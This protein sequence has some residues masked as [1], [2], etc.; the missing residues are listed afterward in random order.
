VSQQQVQINELNRAVVHLESRVWGNLDLLHSDLDVLCAEHRALGECLVAT[1]MLRLTTIRARTELCWTFGLLR[2]VLSHSSLLR[3]VSQSADS[4]GSAI[5]CF[6]LAARTLQDVRKQVSHWRAHGEVEVS[7]SGSSTS[8]AVP[9][10][11]S[12][13]SGH[14]GVADTPPALSDKD[15]R[16]LSAG[17][18][19][20]DAELDKWA[21]S[22]AVKDILSSYV[23]EDVV[24]S[25]DTMRFSDVHHIFVDMGLCIAQFVRHFTSEA[26]PRH[27]C[28]SADIA[29]MANGILRRFVSNPEDGEA[30]VIRHRDLFRLLEATGYSLSRFCA[31]FTNRNPEAPFVPGR[32]P[33]FGN[34]LICR[35]IGAG[36]HG[37][38]CYL[39]QHVHSAAQVAIK[40]PVDLQEL[41]TIRDIQRHWGGACLG[42]ARLID[43]GKYDGHLYMVTELL[44][45]TF[46]K[47]FSR[48][49]QALPLEQRWDALSIIGR[50]LVR[51]L[52]ALH[53]A[54]HVHCDISPENILLGHVHC[55]GEATPFCAPFFI[56][57]GLARKYPDGGVLDGQ[58]G[59]AEWNSISSADDIERR[60]EDDLEAL[61]WVMLTGLFGALPWMDWLTK[62]Y[63]DWKTPSTRNGVLRRV[64]RAKIQLLEAG[65]DSL[66]GWASFAQ[67]PRQLDS[68]LRECRSSEAPPGQPDYSYLLALLGCN[69][70]L[71]T[72]EA[73]DEDLRQFRE[74]ITPWL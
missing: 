13:S 15:L 2:S 14:K 51:R 30:G 40:W 26:S 35:E 12:T 5:H 33:Q 38:S 37:V 23:V 29:D 52:K 69:P 64:Q 43:S 59:S 6:S 4:V 45:S 72:Q 34:Y 7:S 63:P 22:A 54:G 44:G 71:R 55:E 42:V 58:F 47:V 19:L 56:D 74:S 65:W 57:F 3:M 50:M 61:G 31:K 66:E 49:Q 62:A 48:L 11:K 32:K 17:K 68:F 53:D 21:R 67:V 16:K 25:V 9:G 24:G 8:K 73:E 46:T 18:E 27:G 28:E 36:A 1:R 20:S 10:R 41:D 39:G 70:D 60:P